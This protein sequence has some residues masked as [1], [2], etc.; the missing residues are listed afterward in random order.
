MNP[1]CCQIYY[2]C[3]FKE[4]RNITLDKESEMLGSMVICVPQGTLYIN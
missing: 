1:T 4:F 3:I 2:N